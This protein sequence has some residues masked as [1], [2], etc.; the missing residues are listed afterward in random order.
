MS[1]WD[2]PCIRYLNK[3]LS[4]CCHAGAGACLQLLH[5]VVLVGPS[6]YQTRQLSLVQGDFHAS[7]AI[8]NLHQK[9]LND[10][11]G[12]A[13]EGLTWVKPKHCRNVSPH[14]FSTA[15]TSLGWNQLPPNGISPHPPPPACETSSRFLFSPFWRTVKSRTFPMGGLGNIRLK[16]FQGFNSAIGNITWRSSTLLPRFFV[17]CWRFLHQTSTHGNL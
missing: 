11:S 1:A 5:G 13:S 9:Q 17:A 3:F 10:S 4:C 14:K 6:V 8:A 15:N 7:V 12:P 16:T 2:E